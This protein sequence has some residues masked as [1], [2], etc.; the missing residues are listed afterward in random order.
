MK[1]TDKLIY[2]SHCEIVLISACY[3]QSKEP[4]V[5]ENEMHDGAPYQTPL[6]S[7]FKVDDN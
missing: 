5:Y 6:L 1:N 2:E 7:I 3:K 4:K